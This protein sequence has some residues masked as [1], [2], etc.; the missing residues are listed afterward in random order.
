MNN[1]NHITYTSKDGKKHEGKTL[2]EKN[3]YTVIECKTCGFKHIVPIPEKEL[4][5]KLYKEEFYSSEKP[6]YLTENEEDFDWWELTYHLYYDMLERNIKSTSKKLLEI[7]SGPG[8][9]LKIGKER[10]WDVTGFE[11]SKL[12]YEYSKKFEV[13]VVNKVFNRST[14]SE[15]GK[16]DVVY[17][18]TVIE[19]IDDP[20]TLISDVKSVLKPN[21]LFC[22]IAPNDYNPLQMLLKDKLGYMP[23]WVAPPQH[24][25]Y[26]D[27][28]SMEKLLTKLGFEVLESSATFPMEFF[29]L[30]GQNYV[31]DNKLG[32]KCHFMRKK[33][34]S[35]LYMHD[36]DMLIKTYNFFAENRIGREF[37]LLGEL[38]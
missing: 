2:D 26:F 31:D 25:N 12:A 23:Y 5:N 34:E 19:H 32:R 8:F 29:L 33:L 38:V 14:A 11:P 37:I 15:S 21:G 6:R 1:I 35:N 10:G 4:L 18:E 16:F 7:G 20:E 9:F 3:G 13:S 27:F 36:K 28:D 30:S 24:I 22:V 17:M